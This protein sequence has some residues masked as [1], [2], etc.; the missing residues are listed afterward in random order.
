[1]Y[2]RAELFFLV[3]ETKIPFKVVLVPFLWVK[4]PR[5]SVFLITKWQIPFEVSRG[6]RTGKGPR[7]YFK[8]TSQERS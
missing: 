4:L 8:M 1:M 3:C 2:A 6:F 7:E 5:Y